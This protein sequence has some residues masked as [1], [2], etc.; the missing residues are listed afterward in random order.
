MLVTAIY[1]ILLF[2]DEKRA[3]AEGP[4]HRMVGKALAIKGTGLSR[5][6]AGPD[7]RRH[8]AYGEFILIVRFSIQHDAVETFMIFLT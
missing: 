7:G 8:Y 4:V 1:A 3:I 2:P 5:E 6:R